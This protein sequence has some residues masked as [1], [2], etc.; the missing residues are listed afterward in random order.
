MTEETKVKI[1]VVD[2]TGIKHDPYVLSHEDVVTVPASVAKIWVTHG[3]AKYVGDAPEEI[4]P[5]QAA[6][7]PVTLNVDKATHSSK[8]KVR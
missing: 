4:Q 8:S 7:E 6:K 5:A 1:E 3:W 2:K